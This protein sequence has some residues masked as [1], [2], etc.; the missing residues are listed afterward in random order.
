MI[1]SSVLEHP[2]D[3]ELAAA[4][5]RNLFD[6]FRAMAAALGGEL[7]EGDLLCRHL[8]SP[9]NPMFKGV[10]HARLA[11]ELVDQLIDE[12]IAWFDSRDAPFFFWWTGPSTTPDDLGDRLIERG[13][14]SMEEQSRQFAPGIMSTLAGSPGMAADLNR[15]DEAVLET[16]PD[17]FEIEDVAD[18]TSL[19]DFGG[20]LRDGMGMP[21]WAAQGWVDATLRIGIGR[22]PWRMYLGRLKGQPVATNMLF[23]GGG[24]ASVYG[25]A[26]LPEAR[27]QG[28]GGAITLKPLLDA[29]EEGYR[30][31]VL[32]SSD[33]A[34]HTYQR[35]GFRPINAR[36][37]R[38][39]WRRP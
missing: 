31:A 30:H 21:D 38:Y 15:M 7:D 11:P 35:I 2:T 37:N 1:L 36:I 8:T 26:T 13:L 27:G 6:L 17:G 25:V 19:L 39:L 20:T 18:R 5:E 14:I 10:W 29:R 23:N 16:V 24:V 4:V 32:F 34:V 28:I 22:T 12:S 33:M 3:A 9:S